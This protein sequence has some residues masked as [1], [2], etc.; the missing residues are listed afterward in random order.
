VAEE[1]RVWGGRIEDGGGEGIK[2]KIK[3]IK[4]SK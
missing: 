3:M 4:I 2:I 1:G